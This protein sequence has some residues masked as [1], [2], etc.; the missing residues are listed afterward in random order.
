MSAYIPVKLACFGTSQGLALSLYM[1]FVNRFQGITYLYR[2]NFFVKC[3]IVY[4]EMVQLREILKY[5]ILF[6]LRYIFYHILCHWCS[7]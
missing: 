1:N 5:K 2:I 4:K 7:F 6:M 3:Y